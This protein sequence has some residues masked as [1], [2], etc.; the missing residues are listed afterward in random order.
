MDRPVD[1]LYSDEDLVA[2]DKPAGML[3]HPVETGQEGTLAQA[4]AQLA[5]G[6]LHLVHR[7]DRDTSGVVL[8]AR[9]RAAHRH[10][11]RQLRARLVR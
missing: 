11:E 1:I 6:P 4:A 7:L 9:S 3:C 5:G 8:L 2:V 10:L